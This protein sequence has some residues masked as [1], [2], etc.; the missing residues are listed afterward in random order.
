MS[1]DLVASGSAIADGSAV[2]SDSY[3]S[4]TF[5]ANVTH[6]ANFL[7][8]FLCIDDNHSEYFAFVNLILK[9]TDASFGIHLVNSKMTDHFSQR[10]HHLPQTTVIV[11][12]VNY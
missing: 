11:I 12:S 9:V 1:L 4:L 8:T 10:H 2:N 3:M 5:V 7:K 6:Y